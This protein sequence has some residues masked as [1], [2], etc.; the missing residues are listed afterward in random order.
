MISS[1]HLFGCGIAIVVIACSSSGGTGDGGTD[2]GTTPT[3]SGTTKDTGKDTSN[4]NN[5]SGNA[6]TCPT[7]DDVSNFMP[8]AF[9]PPVN[10]PMACTGTQ[11]QGYY[12][13]CLNSMTS[14]TMKCQAFI[15]ANMACSKCLET[16]DTD[17]MWGAVIDLQSGI[18]EINL[19]GCV[20]I[21]GDMNCGKA[22]QAND[23]C[24]DAA[25]GMVCPVM[26][27]QSFQD[28]EKCVSTAETKGCSKYEMGLKTA[29]STEAGS[30]YATCSNFQSFDDGFFVVAPIFCGG[31]ND[32]GGGG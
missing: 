30:A 32:G 12:D 11:V 13:N 7:P 28:Y 10:T 21:L 14:S 16:A 25:C 29:C 22:I 6:P 5:D 1:K 2:T 18:S 19:S 20:T 24:T 3:D 17:Q 26:D 8:P 31:S 27:D 9:V 23:A 15:M 4:N